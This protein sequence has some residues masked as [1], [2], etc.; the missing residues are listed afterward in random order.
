MLELIHIVNG[1]RQ[2]QKKI[3]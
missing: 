2:M 1:N 3:R